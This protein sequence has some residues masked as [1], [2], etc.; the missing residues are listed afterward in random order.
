MVDAHGKSDVAKT[1]FKIG[2][3]PNKM[4]GVTLTI[5]NTHRNGRDI[6]WYFDFVVPAR[7]PRLGLKST[8]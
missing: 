4:A 3:D 6:E 7:R 8:A 5:G 2:E 1:T